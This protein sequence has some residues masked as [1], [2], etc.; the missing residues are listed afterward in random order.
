LINGYID[1]KI[2]QNTFSKFSSTYSVLFITKKGE[3][4]LKSKDK[5]TL[6]IKGK[7]IKKTQKIETDKK[8][9]GEDDTIEKLKKLLY[10]ERANL[11]KKH[12]TTAYYVFSELT[13]T[14]FAKKKPKTVKQLQAIDGVARANISNYGIAMLKVIRSFCADL[15]ECEPLTEKE[16][17]EMER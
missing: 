13:I 17:K 11:A 3:N 6:K 16:L 1:E 12:A 14:E 5:I 15:G 4:F 7:S 2:I 9:L 10:E 8:K